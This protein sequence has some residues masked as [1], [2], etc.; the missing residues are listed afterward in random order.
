MEE[1][2]EE[3]ERRRG[4]IRIFTHPAAGT[5][6]PSRVK[7]SNRHLSHTLTTSLVVKTDRVLRARTMPASRAFR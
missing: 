7:L 6:Q 2:E 4:S 5:A 1:E 3:E